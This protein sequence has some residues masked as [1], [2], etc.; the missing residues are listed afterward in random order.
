MVGFVL[1]N[2]AIESYKDI[3]E[4]PTDQETHIIINMSGMI[5]LDGLERFKELTDLDISHNLIAD[6]SIISQLKKLQNLNLAYNKIKAIPANFSLKSLTYLD[7]SGNLIEA[8]KLPT[9]F[10]LLR[11]LKLKNNNIYEITQNWVSNIE[12]LELS[13]NKIGRGKLLSFSLFPN[14]TSLSLKDNELSV[15]PSISDLKKLSSLD[16]SHNSIAHLGKSKNLELAFLNLSH[17]KIKILDDQGFYFPGLLSLDIRNNLIKSPMSLNGLKNLELLGEIWLQENPICHIDFDWISYLFSE[18]EQLNSIDNIDRE[19]GDFDGSNKIENFTNN[20]L[21]PI[22][23]LNDTIQLG[24]Q[25]M[26]L[27]RIEY[28]G[29]SNA[30]LSADLEQRNSSSKPDL[31]LQPLISIKK[32]R[33]SMKSVNSKFIIKSS[34]SLSKTNLIEQNELLYSLLKKN[35]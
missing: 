27:K 20:R 10:K 32:S 14:L 2:K 15:M 25:K 11:I 6:I 33:K 18:F 22:N 28:R 30:V 5:R 31:N 12:E 26:N 13:G 9:D 7:L 17:N 29:E 8:I 3:Q 1:L 34:K 24:I 21:S 35:K 16:L 23:E 4:Q 19:E